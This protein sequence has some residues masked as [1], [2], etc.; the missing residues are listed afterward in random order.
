[1]SIL[2]GGGEDPRNNNNVPKKRKKVSVLGDASTP[3][4]SRKPKKHKH[5]AMDVSSGEDEMDSELNRKNNSKSTNNAK[6]NKKPKSE[7]KKQKPPSTKDGNKSSKTRTKKIKPTRPP[8]TLESKSTP[9]LRVQIKGMPEIK[10]L[11]ELPVDNPYLTNDDKAKFPCVGMTNESLLRLQQARPPRLPSS[12]SSSKDEKDGMDTSEDNERESETTRIKDKA[13][14][15]AAGAKSKRD[16]EKRKKEIKDAA[17]ALIPSSK[18]IPLTSVSA[19]LQAKIDRH[20]KVET[21]VKNRADWNKEDQL[22]ALKHGLLAIPKLKAS[23]IQNILRAAGKWKYANGKEYNFPACIK[24]YA[25]VCVC[26]GILIRIHTHTQVPNASVPRVCTRI[27]THSM[28]S[29]T[30]SR[31]L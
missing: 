4:V 31:V 14:A 9:L 24:G 22:N 18:E 19:E 30:H 23:H 2:D 13:A 28:N 10:D 27:I 15:E 20:P 7:S 6:K 16:R 26:A 3:Q 1:M 29:D 21:I 17:D 25:Y 5:R 12:S 8:P 11:S